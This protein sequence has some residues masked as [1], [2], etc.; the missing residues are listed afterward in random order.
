MAELSLTKRKQLK[1]QLRIWLEMGWPRR[2]INEE[3]FNFGI[4]PLQATEIINEIRHEQKDD[5]SI[6]RAEFLA[7]QMARLEQLIMQ[8]QEEGNLGV[9]LGCIKELNALAKL[10]TL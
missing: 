6:E 2:R 10:H 1:Q 3:C 5:M 8:A 9:A 7:Q 4:N